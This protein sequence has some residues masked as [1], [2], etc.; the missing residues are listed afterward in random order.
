[1]ALNRTEYAKNGLCGVLTPQA[2]TTVEPE[3]WALLP[4]DQSLI[5]ARLVSEKATIEERLIDYTHRFSE[6]AK[7][8]SNAPITCL[9]AACTGAS[10]LIG[11]AHEAEIV[12]EMQVRFGVPFLTAALSTVSALRAT[13]AKRIALLSPYPDSLNEY[14]LPYWESFDF[15]VVSLA[16]PKLENTA[17]HSIYAMEESGVVASYRELSETDAD[18]VLMLGTG[19]ATLG[20]ILIGLDEGLKPAIS[21]NLALAWSTAQSE[22]LEKLDHNT[23]ETWGKAT[24]WRG[25]YTVLRGL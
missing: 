15:E 10:Y 16:G 7:R 5:T 21:C 3:L 6:T 1:M 12:K 23:F 8:F 22:Q 20:A 4:P 2:N 17:F 18:T 13:N 11:A 19:M 9:A 24:N 25:R 14:C